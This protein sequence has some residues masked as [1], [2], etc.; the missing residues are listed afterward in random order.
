M[1][2]SVSCVELSRTRERKAKLRKCKIVEKI[3]GIFCKYEIISL[4]DDRNKSW[5]GQ[6]RRG[7]QSKTGSHWKVDGVAAG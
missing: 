5:Y 2:L 4:R 7:Q 3:Y 6:D 1:T